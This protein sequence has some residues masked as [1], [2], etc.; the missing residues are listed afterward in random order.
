V[1][2]AAQRH[3]EGHAPEAVRAPQVTETNRIRSVMA[4][5]DDWHHIDVAP[6]GQGRACSPAAASAWAATADAGLGPHWELQ[7]FVQGGMT[8]LQA[9]RVGTLYPAQTL[10]LD[11]DL[12]SIEPGKLADFVVLD[13]NPL[14]DITNSTAWAWW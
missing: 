13:K 1:V 5:D 2:P 8:P 14:D 4:D 6:L 9:L 10:G 3:L 12:G 11:G 7:A